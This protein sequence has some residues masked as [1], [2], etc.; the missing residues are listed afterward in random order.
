[1]ANF[2]SNGKTVN[3]LGC[4]NYSTLSFQYKSGRKYYVNKYQKI[5]CSNKTLNRE[6]HS[7]WSLFYSDQCFKT[8]LRY[9]TWGKSFECKFKQRSGDTL[10]VRLA[11]KTFIFVSTCKWYIMSWQKRRYWELDIRKGTLRLLCSSKWIKISKFTTEQRSS[12]HKDRKGK[13][14]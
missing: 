4:W 6:A 11:N 10:E 5:C 13:K 3:I 14:L 9:I 7:C 12:S 1:M 8:V 2:V